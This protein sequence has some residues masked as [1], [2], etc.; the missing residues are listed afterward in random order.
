M[1]EAKNLSKSFGAVN[2]LND[3]NLSV[4][5]SIMPANAPTARCCRAVPDDALV[6]G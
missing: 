2:A 3:L 5:W 1:L 6:R 4:T